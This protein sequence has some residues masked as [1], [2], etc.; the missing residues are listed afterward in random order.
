M[1]ALGFAGAFLS[2]QST[3]P[4]VTRPLLARRATRY[5]R[6]N[7]RAYAGNT[8]RKYGI[9][10]A[11]HS[12]IV[13]NPHGQIDSRGV[14]WARYS[15]HFTAAYAGGMSTSPVNTTVHTVHD[16]RQ[17]SRRGGVRSRNG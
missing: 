2:F 13:P 14:Q 9:P 17:R 7:R 4:I 16:H 6:A 1:T 8:T 11:T 15:C 10:W 3:T 5:M 12:A